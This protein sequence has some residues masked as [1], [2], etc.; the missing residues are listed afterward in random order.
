MI[1]PPS[2]EIVEAEIEGDLSLYDPHSAEVLVLNSTASDIWRLSDGSLT[3]EEMVS[4]LAEFY[5][6]EPDSIRSEVEATVGALVV[7]G[8]LP[9]AA[10]A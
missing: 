2:N 6:A 7:R 8:F 1:G 5:G 9:D 3:L 4:V 10:P